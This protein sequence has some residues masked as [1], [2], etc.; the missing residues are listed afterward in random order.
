MIAEL[1]GTKKAAT[2]L[3]T[4]KKFMHPTIISKAAAIAVRCVKSN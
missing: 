1:N 3:D 4:I 2:H